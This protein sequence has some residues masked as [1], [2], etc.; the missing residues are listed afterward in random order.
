MAKYFLVDFENTGNSGLAGCN[1]LG[2]A[3]KIYIFHTTKESKIDVSAIKEHDGAAFVLLKI[4]PGKQ[5]VDIHIGSYL[6]YLAAITKGNDDNAIVIV[7]KDTD[8][9]ALIKFWKMKS[10]IKIKRAPRIQRYAPNASMSDVKKR[11]NATATSKSELAPL[12][13]TI[14]EILREAGY[15]QNVADFTASTVVNN[16]GT[17]HA[18]QQ[19]YSALIKKN[20]QANGLE[21]YN[22]IKK[23]L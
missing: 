9:D 21:I 18:K 1:K 22:L 15:P 8:Y 12:S 5:S 13:N 16:S 23:R 20:G 3:D 17:K 6:G 10:G 2:K 19:V 11:E 14:K 4:P 7:S